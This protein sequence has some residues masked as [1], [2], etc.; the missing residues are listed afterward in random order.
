MGE[1]VAHQAKVDLHCGPD[2]GGAQGPGN[3]GVILHA[4]NVGYTDN[5]GEDNAEAVT[6]CVSSSVDNNARKD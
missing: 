6:T 5:R 4:S 1:A 2:S 3:V